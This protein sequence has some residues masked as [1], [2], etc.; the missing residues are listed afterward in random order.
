MP[1]DRLE[2]VLRA[3]EALM[4]ALALCRDLLPGG[5]WI[6]A[7]AVRNSVWDHLHGR[8]PGLAGDVDVVFFDTGIGLDADSVFQR[9]LA[10]ARPD[11]G[12]DVSNQAHV[13]TWYRACFGKDVPAL[14]TLAQGIATWPDTAT[15]VAVRMDDDGNLEVV[16]PFGLDDLFDLVLR[17]NPARVGF[18]DFEARIAAK[19]WLARWPR[20][21]LIEAAAGTA[22]PGNR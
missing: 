10:A 1:M 20:L 7:G 12:W 15:A 8:A 11:I 17:W 21:H 4:E 9:T 3:N 19:G 16:A 5:A 2:R 13:H 6:G 14:A 22:R 18:E